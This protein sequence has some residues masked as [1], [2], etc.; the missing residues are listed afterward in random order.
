MGV[1]VNIFNI[2]FLIKNRDGIKLTKSFRNLLS[3]L[4]TFDLLYLLMAIGIFA[5]PTLSQTYEDNI[6][7]KILPSW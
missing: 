5:L 6:F 1:L 7:P 3:I 2:F 4:A